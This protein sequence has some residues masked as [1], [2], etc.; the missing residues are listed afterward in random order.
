M[1]SVTNGFL[2]RKTILC[3]SIQDENCNTYTVTS[4]LSGHYEKIVN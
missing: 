2:T 4:Y 3:N 1:E